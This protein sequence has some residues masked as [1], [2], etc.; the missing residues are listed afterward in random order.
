[1]KVL[2][3]E[4]DRAMRQLMKRVVGDLVDSFCE[5]DDGRDALAAYEADRPDWV[6]MDIRM[7]DIDGLAATEQIVNAWPGAR[8]L[9]VTS[10][11]RRQLWRHQLAGGST[12]GGRVRVC[13]QR[14]PAR[15]APLAR[16]QKPQ[17]L[18]RGPGRHLKE[19]KI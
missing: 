2:I 19:R 6:L 7:K 16:K 11:G 9:I 4:D 14:G 3:V 12:A 8:V 5:C 13:P 18:G 10:Y 17:S 15:S 1:M